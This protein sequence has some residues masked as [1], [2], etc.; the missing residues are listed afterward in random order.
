MICQLIKNTNNFG[1]H[2]AS[3]EASDSQPNARE[4][5]VG[6]GRGVVTVCTT[7]D[8]EQGRVL[9]RGS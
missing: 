4:A 6:Q 1:W 2:K 5:L 3:V 8:I 9:T 7:V